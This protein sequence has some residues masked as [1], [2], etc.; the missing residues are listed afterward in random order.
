MCSGKTLCALG[1]SQTTR[2]TSVLQIQGF[3][4]R[5]LQ[6]SETH[7]RQTGLGV[8]SLFSILVTFGEFPNMFVSNLVVCN[9]CA[10]ELFCSLLHPFCALLRSFADLRLRSFALIC[11][12][13]RSFACFCVRPRLERPRLGTAI[14]VTF[15]TLLS[16][17]ASLLLHLERA[18]RGIAY[19]L[20]GGPLVS[21]EISKIELLL[22]ELELHIALP[23][24]AA[25]TSTL[26]REVRPSP[27]KWWA[28]CQRD[29]LGTEACL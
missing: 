18:S 2:Q 20:G 25:A 22:T 7:F 6:G 21:R 8:E 16:L 19:P 23:N 29:T 14:S 15:L 1:K 28:P 5:D 11:V 9:F 17:F 12:I 24:K 26:S 27:P 13:L 3:R 10:E 4:L